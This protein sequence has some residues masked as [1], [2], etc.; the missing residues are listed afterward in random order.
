MIACWRF[1]LVDKVYCTEFGFYPMPFNSD[2]NIHKKN[3]RSLGPTRYSF[4]L[5]NGTKVDIVLFKYF[6]ESKYLKTKGI[7]NFFVHA[8]FLFFKT[9]V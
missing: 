3:A 5:D 1:E 2:S 6:L 8:S 9:I 7:M 4:M